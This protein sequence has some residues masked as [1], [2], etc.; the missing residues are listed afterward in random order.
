M[1]GVLYALNKDVETQESSAEFSAETGKKERKKSLW[2][3]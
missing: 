2:M 3:D 1:S